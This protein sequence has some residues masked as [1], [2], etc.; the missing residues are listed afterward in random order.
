MPIK[1]EII[2]VRRVTVKGEKLISLRIQRKTTKGF[3]DIKL[4]TNIHINPIPNYKKLIGTT[5]SMQRK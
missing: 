2:G 3:K 5:V 1:W 4:T